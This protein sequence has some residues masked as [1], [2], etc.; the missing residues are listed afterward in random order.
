[1]FL[2]KMMTHESEAVKQIDQYIVNTFERDLILATL[3][4]WNEID[5]NRMGCYSYSLMRS[6]LAENFLELLDL[7][8]GQGFTVTRRECNENHIII[9]F[10]TQLLSHMIETV[11]DVKQDTSVSDVWHAL[12]RIVNVTFDDAIVTIETMRIEG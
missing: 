7:I 3:L 8:D 6:M 4:H 2:E 12:S 5:T 1:M 10:D 9:N 11:I